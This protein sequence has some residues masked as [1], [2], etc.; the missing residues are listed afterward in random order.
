LTKIQEH[1]YNGLA[2]MDLVAHIDELHAL[3]RRDSMAYAMRLALRE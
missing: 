3:W 1:L 2:L